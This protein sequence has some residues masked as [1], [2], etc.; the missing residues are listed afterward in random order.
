MAYRALVPIGEAVGEEIGLTETTYGESDPLENN[1]VTPFKLHRSWH[2]FGREIAHNWTHPLE[3]GAVQPT[4]TKPHLT[5]TGKTIW[6][7]AK[8]IVGATVVGKE[9]TQIWHDI[10][11]GKEPTPPSK[12]P[13]NVPVTPPPKPTFPDPK[14]PNPTTPNDPEEKQNPIIINIKGPGT[15]TGPPAPIHPKRQRKGRKHY[16]EKRHHKKK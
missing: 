8:D 5:S 10:H 11:P 16:T 9:A 12:P 6:H 15:S 7:A 13:D 3:A 1:A 14:D 4:N 2:Q